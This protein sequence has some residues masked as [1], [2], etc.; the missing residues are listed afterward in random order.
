MHCVDIDGVDYRVVDDGHTHINVYSKGKT[1]LGRWLSNFTKC[2]VQTVYGEFDSMEGLYHFLKIKLSY[3]EAGIEPTDD[4]KK[5]LDVLKIVS[6]KMAQTLGRDIKQ[7]VF[8]AKVRVIEK[9]SEAFEKCFID[10]MSY[11]L[12]SNPTM[13]E[14]LQ[15][16]L[17]DGKCLLHYYTV[18]RKVV[19]KNHFKWLCT[20]IEKSLEQI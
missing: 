2:K 15:E 6:G 13:L 17:S 3:E 7:D 1:A 12:K 20:M 8:K 19:Y 9:P 11:K 10:A 16:E 18:G 14:N 4:I 5:R